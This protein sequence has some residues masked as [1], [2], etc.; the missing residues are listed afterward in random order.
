MRALISWAGVH[1]SAGDGWGDNLGVQG[2][3]INVERD[4]TRVYDAEVSDKLL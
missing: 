3:E 4:M 2:H 1:E